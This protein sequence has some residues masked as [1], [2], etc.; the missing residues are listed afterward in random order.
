[1][2]FT[3][4]EDPSMRFFADSELACVT[5]G[6]YVTGS[7][8]GLSGIYA[9]PWQSNAGAR[10]LCIVPGFVVLTNLAT[11]SRDARRRDLTGDTEA[12]K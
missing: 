3:A 2:P 12:A 5:F 6:L 1:M 7:S 9:L 11:G 4:R 10:I 8:L